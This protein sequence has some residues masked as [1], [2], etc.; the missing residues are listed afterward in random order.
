MLNKIKSFA[1]FCKSSAI[2]LKVNK[3]M[4]SN[5][6]GDVTDS[7]PLTLPSI[8]TITEKYIKKIEEW[9]K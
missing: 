9:I 8:T 7:Y 2:W 3:V 4:L 6:I 1:N 5:L